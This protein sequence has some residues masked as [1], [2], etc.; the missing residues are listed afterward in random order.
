MTHYQRQLRD[1]R[2]QRRRL[3]IFERDG[4]ACVE[5]GARDKELQVHHTT[6][7]WG[8]AP[9]EA[10]T[11]SLVTLCVTCHRKHRKTTGKARTTGKVKKRKWA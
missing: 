4:W 6:Y 11:R 7:V 10:P 9:W 5:C 2:W 3:H 8:Q 1:P